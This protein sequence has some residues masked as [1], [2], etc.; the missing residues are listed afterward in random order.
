MLNSFMLASSSF[1]LSSFPYCLADPHV[2]QFSRMQSSLSSSDSSLFMVVSP[3]RLLA[4]FCDT[5]P[6]RG[7]FEY[8]CNVPRALHLLAR[9]NCKPLACQWF[10][11]GDFCRKAKILSVR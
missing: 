3:F 7:V 5:L 9:G 4:M 8:R 6:G 1:L 11:D 10:K 2:N